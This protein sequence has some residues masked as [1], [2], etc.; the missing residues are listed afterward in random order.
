MKRDL[1]FEVEYHY[2]PELVWKV[3]TDSK[4]MEKWLMPN[5]FELK[6]GHQ[7]TLRTAPGP[8]FDGIVRC[9]VLGFIDSKFLEYSW[10]GG[11]VDTIVRFHLSPTSGGTRLILEHTGFQGWKS[12][13]TSFILQMGWKSKILKIGIPRVLQE[14]KSH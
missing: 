14:H 11:P 5:D 3:I 12:Y 9:E 7:F 2:A 8:G 13:F 4:L 10:K 1:S 6:V